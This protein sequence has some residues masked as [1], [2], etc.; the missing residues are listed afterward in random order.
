MTHDLLREVVPSAGYE[1]DEEGLGL[2]ERYLELLER[3][4]E[5]LDLT[6]IRDR[7][8]LVRRQVGESLALLRMIEEVGLSQGARLT[9]VGSGGGVPGIPI[10]IARP[11]L[12]IVLIESS[13]R[14]AEWL[15]AT[16]EQLGIKASVLPVRAEQAGRDP[17]HRESA[18][19]VVA[20]AV[21]PLPTLLEMTIPLLKPGA[22]LFAA[23]GSQLDQELV[24]SASALQAL[25]AEVVI[26][27]P[28]SAIGPVPVVLVVRKLAVTAHRFPRSPA[29]V[30][31]RLL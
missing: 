12:D 6:A 14:K 16:C 24:Q 8:E 3:D 18:D 10:A 27:K 26:R 29:A 30:R 20:K 28:L 21:A 5:R 4:R 19:A 7:Q 17:R 9:D 25:A 1:L 22:C 13:T 11:D 15:V 31:K 2:L 23:K